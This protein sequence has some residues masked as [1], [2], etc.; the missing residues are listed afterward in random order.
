M[1]NHR[2]IHLALAIAIL[3]A[4]LAAAQPDAA[5]L[6]GPFAKDEYPQA[7]IDRP[8]TLPAGMVEGELAATFTSVRVD[9]S[10]FLGVRGIDEWTADVALRVG[11]TDWLQ[12]EAGTA[13]SLDYVQ[14]SGDFV[15]GID[16]RDLRPSL[17]SWKRV[18]PLRVALLALDTDTLDT[19]V[20]VTL[21]FV[22]HSTREYRFGRGGSLV[23]STPGNPRVLPVV[24][25]DAPTRWRLTDRLWLRAGENLFAVTTTDTVA[26]FAFD[27]GVGVQPHRMFALTLDSRIASVAFAGDGD[28]ASE[29]VCDRGTLD[30]EGTFA[31]L[32]FFD[33]V[34]SAALPDV[35]DGFDDYV[36]RIG[37][38][39]RL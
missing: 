25:L 29:T 34:G 4:P 12:V 16:P 30:L 19:A 6:V 9:P 38:R 37:V 18:V 15:Q 23:L 36:L 1:A 20:R 7:L 26:A 35:G 13:F 2:P 10:E 39:V 28:S 3:V 32:P 17:T 8:L 27:F 21:P 22:G 11:V 14:R 33:V 5:R 24:A 31:P